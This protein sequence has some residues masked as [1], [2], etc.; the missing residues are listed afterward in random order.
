MS[1]ERPWRMCLFPGLKSK[2]V[3]PVLQVN[4]DDKEWW[5]MVS[6]LL[7]RDVVSWLLL[8]SQGKGL[9]VLYYILPFINL[10]AKGSCELKQPTSLVPPLIEFWPHYP[11]CHLGIYENWYPCSEDFWHPTSSKQ[12][13]NT[14]CL[15][16]LCYFHFFLSCSITEYT[17][18]VCNPSWADQWTLHYIT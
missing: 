2:K 13:Q 14:L 10:V 5:E 17:R 12:T 7:R 11:K 6:H 1:S 8:K 18:N 9:P 3:K 4:E 16:S 15:S